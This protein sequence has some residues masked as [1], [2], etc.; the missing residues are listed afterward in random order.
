VNKACLIALCS[1]TVSLSNAQSTPPNPL[2]FDLSKIGMVVNGEQLCEDKGRLQDVPSKEMDQIIAAG[3]KAVPVLI[4]MID[5]NRMAQT[6]EPIVCYWPGMTIGDIAVCLLTDLFTDPSYTKT[7][8]AGAD[9]NEM[10]GPSN[11]LPA[12]EQ[13]HAFTKKHGSG[14][15]QAKWWRLWDKYGGQVF[16]DPRERCFKLKSQ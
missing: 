14:A 1:L 16:W 7:T 12:W 4:G 6:K 8:L 3:P 11:N 2:H 9:W 10:L 15:L 13:L 5:D